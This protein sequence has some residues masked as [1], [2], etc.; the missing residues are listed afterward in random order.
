MTAPSILRRRD[1]SRI[2]PPL[3]VGAQHQKTYPEEKKK[4]EGRGSV[5]RGRINRQQLAG[6]PAACWPGT[7]AQRCCLTLGLVFAPLTAFANPGFFSRSFSASESGSWEGG[8][9]SIKTN[10]KKIREI[11][12]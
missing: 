12:N 6:A 2:R 4:K 7:G 11:A 8:W 10:G 5:Q 9:L 1:G 3:A